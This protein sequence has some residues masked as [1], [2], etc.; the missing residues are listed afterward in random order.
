MAEVA[1]TRVDKGQNCTTVYVTLS[2]GRTGV[3][4][5]WHLLG[6]ANERTVHEATTK[7]IQDANKKCKP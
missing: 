5:A 2:D 7:A 6:S 3:G 1:S 4:E